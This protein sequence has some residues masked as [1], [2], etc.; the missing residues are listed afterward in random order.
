MSDYPHPAAGAVAMTNDVDPAILDVLRLANDLISTVET[1]EVLNRVLGTIA[2]FSGA[3]RGYI[4]RM[5]NGQLIPGAI[6]PELDKGKTDL[7][8][9]SR[10]AVD[11]AIR[12]RKPLLMGSAPADDARF[13]P[14]KSIHDMGVKS[15]L[16]IPLTFKGDVLGAVYLHHTQR[17]KAFDSVSMPLLET[18]SN[19]AALAIQNAELYKQ[20]ITDPLTGLFS[21]RYFE[22][23]VERELS[24]CQ[25]IGKPLAILFLDIDHFKKVNDKYRHDI[26]NL[27]LR[28]I[29]SIISTM[30]RKTDLVTYPG[31]NAAGATAARYG[32]DEFEVMLSECPKA[33]AL[34]VATRLLAVI[35]AKPFEFDRI[36]VPVSVSIGVAGF[37]EDGSDTITVLRR[38]DEA[39]YQ[40][41][42]QG[43]GRVFAFP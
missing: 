22:T 24:K 7:I 38:A 5:K 19:Y 12:T 26:G 31:L 21:H 10:T 30:V 23:V 32:G 36:S 13:N 28:E 14:S 39:M 3:E 2:R 4:V 9:I 27:I 41:K 17:E 6:W 29:G 35:K 15:L 11:L 33:G 16:C 40:A 8:N 34:K 25:R 1:G 37:P 42:R 20:A 43:R 18:L